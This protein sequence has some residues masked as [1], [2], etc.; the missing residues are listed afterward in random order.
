MYFLS[1]G[2]STTVLDI[3]PALA[4]VLFIYAIRIAMRGRLLLC[5]KPLIW[6]RI[7][8]Q[9]ETGANGSVET[10]KLVIDVPHIIILSFNYRLQ[11]KF[12][13][14]TNEVLYQQMKYGWIIGY[15]ILTEV[16][17]INFWPKG[18]LYAGLPS[19]KLTITACNF[20]YI[21]LWKKPRPSPCSGSNGEIG[22]MPKIQ[23][24]RWHW[25][26]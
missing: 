4:L 2:P 9:K 6:I 3:G 22:S 13:R 8:L 20:G 14:N 12:Q 17:P 23:Q 21:K 26:H 15:N 5:S 18:A 19:F 25:W 7:N 11:R 10:I 24:W 16:N 1:W